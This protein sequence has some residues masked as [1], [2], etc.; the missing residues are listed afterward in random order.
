MKISAPRFLTWLIATAAGVLGILIHLNV[1]SLGKLDAYS[2]WYVAG[3]FA[4][5]CIS[6]LFKGL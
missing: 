4:L 6:N 1:L 5:L 2:F 3:G